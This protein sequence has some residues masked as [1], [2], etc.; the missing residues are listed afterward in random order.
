MDDLVDAR[1]LGTVESRDILYLLY[2]SEDSLGIYWP[3]PSAGKDIQWSLFAVECN[4]RR[5][6][7]D[8]SCFLISINESIQLVSCELLDSM[9]VEHVRQQLW[10][11][12]VE[13][14][15]NRFGQYYCITVLL[16]LRALHTAVLLPDWLYFMGD[17][18]WAFDEGTVEWEVVHAYFCLFL[19]VLLL[20]F[21]LF[22]LNRMLLVV[23][24]WSLIGSKVTW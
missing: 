15:K 16:P 23:L 10:W 2:I 22:W 4:R 1:I 7:S 19:L 17:C 8:L 20:F 21:S 13:Y 18:G 6:N 3:D 5:R 14:V 9:I 24:L 12:C 11:S